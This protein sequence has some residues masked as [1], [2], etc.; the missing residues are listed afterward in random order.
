MKRLTKYKKYSIKTFVTHR[1]G[2]S[3]KS[4]EQ[5]AERQ[6]IMVRNLILAISISLTTTTLFGCGSDASVPGGD[7]MTPHFTADF[8]G[9]CDTS[10]GCNDPDCWETSA[11]VHDYGNCQAEIPTN[12]RF[13]CDVP[14]HDDTAEVIF[15]PLHTRG[16]YNSN[17]V[18]SGCANSM[19]DQFALTLVFENINPYYWEYGL[20]HRAETWST[21]ELPFD[22]K[23]EGMDDIMTR[24]PSRNIACVG[25]GQAY[26][27]LPDANYPNGTA[28]LRVTGDSIERLATAETAETKIT[29]LCGYDPSK[30]YMMS[31]DKKID[32]QY[33]THLYMWDGSTLHPQQ[34]P[35]IGDDG[36][37]FD[38]KLHCLPS[39]GLYIA[40][41]LYDQKA[42]L[43][44]GV[45]YHWDGKS[46]SQVPL[47]N[48][49]TGTDQTP[50]IVDITGKTDCDVI[51]VG[52]NGADAFTLQK[53]GDAWEYG[54]D[55][56]L[57]SAFGVAM[58]SKFEYIVQGYGNESTTFGMHLGTSNGD[59]T[60]DWLSHDV[61]GRRLQSLEA[62]WTIPE[63]PNLYI[64]AGKMSE[65]QQ[66]MAYAFTCQ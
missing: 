21:I 57:N 20:S 15:K 30:I 36:A 14:L 3:T 51:A 61:F 65:D 32:G 5:R 22:T 48:V 38:Y 44:T 46:W 66:P 59:F 49:P 52:Y 26:V 34:I 54:G 27:V 64:K 47:T 35:K 8:D 63:N 43:I 10:S 39:G 6:T 24:E 28:F 17:A 4:P 55:P 12:K 60:T 2:S 42:G 9:E 50:V 11:C 31:R 62:A 53:N 29:S 16:T 37:F 40:G 7:G 13:V 33:V 18:I 45:L 23:L 1:G 25:N 41:L 58:N 56:S 19:N